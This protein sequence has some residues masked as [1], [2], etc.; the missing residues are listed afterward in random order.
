LSQLREYCPHELL[1]EFDA[2]AADC[3]QI[4]GFV[5]PLDDSTDWGQFVG[6][7][8]YDVYERLSQLDAD[9]VVAEVIFHGSQNGQPIPFMSSTA[10]FSS[11]PIGTDARAQQL[12]QE[13]MRI[14]NRW[15]ADF[16]SVEPERHAGLAYLPLWNIELAVDELLWAREAGL[17]GVNFPAPRPSLPDYNDPSWEPLWCAAEDLGMAL[18]THGGSETL[19]AGLARYQGPGADRLRV[20]EATLFSHRA[21]SWLVLGGVFERHPRLRLLLAEI[22]GVN[23]WLPSKLLEMDEMA[24]GGKGYFTEYELPRLPSDYFRTNCFVGAS[25]MSRAD[26]VSA[27]EHS[28]EANYLWGSDFP[29]REGSYPHS[30]ASLR[31]ATAGIDPDAVRRIVGLNLV[32]LFGL[33]RRKLDIVAERI[34]PTLEEL[35]APL[36]DDDLPARTGVSEH[37]LAF[38]T[39]F[40][41]V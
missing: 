1:D 22:I 39:G 21:L 14:Y 10:S 28:F 7:A 30:V 8:H 2:F 31:M 38:R 41:W 16:C 17:R 5:S 36:R 20:S 32:D 29:H 13:G 24:T 35:T 9:G 33:D 3:P 6:P 11:D 27:I 26:A 15:L 34:G 37:S 25:F 40:I 23:T 4:P 18:A 12:S 19:T